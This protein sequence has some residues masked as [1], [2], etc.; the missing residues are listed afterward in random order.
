MVGRLGKKFRG[1]AGAEISFQQSDQVMT[2]K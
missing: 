2:E 1:V